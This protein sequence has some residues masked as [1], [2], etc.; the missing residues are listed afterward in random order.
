MK[1]LCPSIA[2]DIRVELLQGMMAR[3][4]LFRDC[5]DRFIVALTSLLEMIALPPYH[6]LFDVGVAGD[7]M[8]VVNSGVLHILVGGKKLR[9]LQQ[10]S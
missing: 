8:Y 4:P 6:T 7:C 9:K 5:N 2:Q 1:L 10:G 3:I